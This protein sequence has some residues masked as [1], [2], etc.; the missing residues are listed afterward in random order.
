M[1]LQVQG[2]F[3]DMNAPC[4]VLNIGQPVLQVMTVLNCVS[5]VLKGSEIS[6]KVI[7]KNCDHHGLYSFISGSLFFYNNQIT[8]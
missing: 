1:I 6:A 7:V 5:R 3:K 8:I 4:N 2:F